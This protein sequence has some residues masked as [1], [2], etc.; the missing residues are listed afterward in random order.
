METTPVFTTNQTVKSIFA[1][2]DQDGKKETQTLGL[3]EAAP[4]A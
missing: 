3:G 4:A 1:H 2:K